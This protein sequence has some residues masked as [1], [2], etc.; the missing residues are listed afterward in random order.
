LTVE[1]W[2][3][4]MERRGEPKP[5][6]LERL[7]L[8]QVATFGAGLCVLV[9]RLA[10]RRV[11]RTDRVKLRVFSNVLATH[12]DSHTDAGGSAPLVVRTLA[13]FSVFL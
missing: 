4:L 10:G 11:K 2:R 6:S 1:L 3:R 8:E 9:K 5:G 13:R 7:G 12:Y